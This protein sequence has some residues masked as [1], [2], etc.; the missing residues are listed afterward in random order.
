[1]TS[2]QTA[3]LLEAAREAARNSYSPYSKF[4]VGAAL[5]SDD[6]TVI[7]G[8]NVE[9]ASFGLTNCAERTAIFKA[10]SEGRR[11]FLALAVA[12]GCAGAPATPCGACRQV[13]AEFCSEDMPVICVPLE[14]DDVLEFTAGELLP[15]GF[16]FVSGDPDKNACTGKGEF[17][18]G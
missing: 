4:A 1:M 17:K 3:K 8:C 12:G 18:N 6:G 11:S 5:L 7:T 2:E 16:D 15:H 13:I 9:N 14:G 10:V